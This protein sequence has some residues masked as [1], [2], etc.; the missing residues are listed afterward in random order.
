MTLT[1]FLLARIAEDEAVAQAAIEDDQGQTE[2]MEDSFDLLTGRADWFGAPTLPKYADDIARL[3]V[4]TAVP[5]RVLADC[6]AKRRVVELHDV[7]SWTT[8]HPHNQRCAMCAEN[9]Y[10]DYDGSPLVDWPCP[11]LRHLAGVYS[12]HPDYQVE[13]SPGYEANE[14]VPTFDIKPTDFTI[15]T[16]E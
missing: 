1:E 4:H 12:D 16:H 7:L 13:W 14:A 5:A 8:K 10:A 3:I 2:G 11:T 9:E 15:R 6:E